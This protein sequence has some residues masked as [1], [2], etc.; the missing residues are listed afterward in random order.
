M[1]LE[2]Q[3]LIEGKYAGRVQG[4]Q[5]VTIYGVEDVDP[6]ADTLSGRR[7]ADAIEDFLRRSKGNRW[8]GC[9]DRALELTYNLSDL[10]YPGRRDIQLHRI[11]FAIKALIQGKCD[12]PIETPYKARH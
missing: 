9:W 5:I 4:S 10:P 6:Y 7:Q 12:V 1:S 2:K 8:E 11:M 3:I